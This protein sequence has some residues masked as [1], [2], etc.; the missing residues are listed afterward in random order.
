MTAEELHLK[1]NSCYVDPSLGNL[2]E[3]YN[4]EQD[5][6]VNVVSRKELKKEYIVGGVLDQE[7]KNNWRAWIYQ[8]NIYFFY[9][10]LQLCLWHI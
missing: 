10:E 4:E 2:H 1:N 7:Q 3:G 9:E 6:C 8:Y 5:I